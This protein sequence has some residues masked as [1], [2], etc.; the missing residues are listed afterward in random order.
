M[1]SGIAS[2][3]ME[4]SEFSKP[5]SGVARPSNAVEKHWHNGGHIHAHIHPLLPV[6]KPCAY[7]ALSLARK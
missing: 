6:N 1:F 2:V 5:Y 7:V 3:T 4:V